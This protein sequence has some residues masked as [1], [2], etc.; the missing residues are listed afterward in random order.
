[1]CENVLFLRI[2]SF[3]NIAMQFLRFV[4]P[5]ILIIKLTL[6]IYKGI[7]NPNDNSFKEKV[8]RRLIACVIIFLVPTII[9]VFFT[10][11][12]F[13]HIGTIIITIINIFFR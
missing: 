1:M 5:I 4:L 12:N 11:I 8:G 13:N 3:F 2:L 10:Q 7:I 9:N 6:D